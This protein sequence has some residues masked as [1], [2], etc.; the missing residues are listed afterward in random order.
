[1]HHITS[2]KLVPV[3]FSAA[4]ALCV[5]ALAPPGAAVGGPSRP[6]APSVSGTDTSVLREWNE[7][8]QGI[9]VGLRPTA[10]G[11]GRGMAMV[12]GAV[13]DAVNAID[14]R[15][16]AY[17]VD[18][19][20]LDIAAGASTD[21]AIATAAHDVLRAIGP[22]SLWVGLDTA[23][24]NTL[25]DVPDGPAEDE[26]V[27]A[28]RAAASAM[29]A[30]R[31]GD[32]FMAPWTFVLGTEAGD[33]RPATPTA[34]DP[35]P[36]VARLKPFLMRSSDQFRTE[37][38]NPLTSAKYTKEFNEVKSLGALDSTTRTPD[39]TTAA[40]FWQT[41]PAA[42]W[43]GL[44]RDLVTGRG[45]G[46]ADAARLLAM[47]NLAVADGGI[48]C[49]SDKYRW[50]FWRPIAAIREAGTDGNPDTAADPGWRS[51]FDPSTP[52]S[53]PL[54]TPPFPDHPS[55]HGC[56]TSSAI[57]SIRSFF[58]TDKIAVDMRSSRFPGEPRHFERLSLV[59]K[60]VIDARVWGGIH[61]RS[62]DVQGTVLGQK[63]VRWMDKHY[64][65]PVG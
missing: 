3:A 36:W 63:V 19:E 21:A 31:V 45:V 56:A 48:S 24:T 29:L 57:N 53:P 14:R 4:V 12:Q 41:P 47:V 5:V 58:G 54:A 33:W 44:A 18:V 65:Q 27:R 25:A 28:G 20:A 38:P 6:T 52:T 64:F 59:V 11:Q 2:R 61:F 46:T 62:A 1:M 22:S 51:L 42:L 30:D 23:L 26:G 9:A 17:L 16:T 37:G 34:L 8:A 32:G 40:I 35:D 13:Y 39:Q 15:H 43:N 7:R 55:G 49:W 10:H 60:E 50:N